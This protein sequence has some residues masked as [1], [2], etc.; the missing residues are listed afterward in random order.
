MHKSARVN[1]DNHIPTTTI[2]TTTTNTTAMM[3][4]IL[5]LIITTILGTQIITTTALI[6]HFREMTAYVH[7]LYNEV[8]KKKTEAEATKG[9]GNYQ[10]PSPPTLMPLLSM[11]R[12]YLTY[13]YTIN[14]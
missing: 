3:L 5:A 10:L 7:S 9:W 4:L 6:F 12:F 13:L 8:D 2:T 14:T 1:N 11:V